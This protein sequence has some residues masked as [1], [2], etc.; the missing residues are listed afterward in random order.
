M[1]FQRVNS[2]CYG[3]KDRGSRLLPIRPDLTGAV[4]GYP[5]TGERRGSAEDWMRVCARQ[6]GSQIGGAAVSEKHA[7]FI[8]AQKGCKSSD[9]R[10]L[11][12]MI[13]NKVRDKFDVTLDLEIELW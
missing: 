1:Q 3:V 7:N 13:R 10:Q 5:W 4:N 2:K 6:K 11:I 8:I 12:D 9:V